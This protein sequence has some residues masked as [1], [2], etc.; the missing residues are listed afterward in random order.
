MTDNDGVIYKVYD[1]TKPGRV[2]YIGQTVRGVRARERGHWAEAKR[3]PE[4]TIPMHRFLRKRPDDGV[5]VV[6]EVLETTPVEFLDDREI[7]WISF[8]RDIGQADL[9]VTDGGGGFR[10]RVYSEE[11]REAKRLSMM[12]RFRGDK[13][14]SAKLTWEDVREIRKHRQLAWTSEEELAEIFGVNQMSI[15]SILRN[16]YWVDEGFDPETIIPRPAYTHANNR[17]IPEET[18]REIRELRMREWVSEKEIARRYGL[19]RSNVNNILR[20]HRWPDP[21]YDPSKLIRAG[22]DGMGSK[23]TPE[24]AEEI[25]GLRGSGLLQREIGDL[26]GISQTQVSRIFRGVRWKS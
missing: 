14:P 11:E 17:Q 25:K 15:N 23:I 2:R 4:S 10:G 6:F 22:G 21:T 24:Q 13:A 3:L 1:A 5:T 26:Y 7:H 19:T 20:A 9:N 16:L 18:V 12:G 8:Y